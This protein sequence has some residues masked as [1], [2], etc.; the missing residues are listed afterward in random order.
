[1]LILGQ[2]V[3]YPLKE[4]FENVDSFVCHPGYNDHLS[5]HCDVGPMLLHCI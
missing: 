2:E 3:Q 4:K 5:I 1:M